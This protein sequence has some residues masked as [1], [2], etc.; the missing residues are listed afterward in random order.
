[1]LINVKIPNVR[2]AGFRIIVLIMTCLLFL[3]VS[4]C[5][6][7]ITRV[8]IT[9][10][11]RV[12]LV[13]REPQNYKSEI[14]EV[15]NIGPYGGGQVCNWTLICETLAAYNVTGIG[16]AFLFNYKAY[17]PSQYVPNMSPR[18]E[19]A[20][21]IEAAHSH[22][23]TVRVEFCILYKSPRNEWKCN[24]SNG[25]VVDWL[26]PTNPE[27]REWIL[28]L[29]EEIVTDY[30]IDDLSLDYIRYDDEDMPY[31]ATAK[32][33]LEEYL[34]E[35]IT[36]WPGDFAPGG[37]RFKE[38]LQWRII[39]I[40]TLVKEIYDLAK[41]IRPNITVSACTRYWGDD[42]GGTLSCVAQDPTAWILD[43]YIDRL[44]PMNYRNTTDLIQRN[45]NAYMTYGT[46]GPKG[47]VE[48]CPYF[49][50]YSQDEGWNLTVTQFAEFITLIRNLGCDG[51]VVSAYM[52]P[53]VNPA[54]SEP[55]PDIRPYLAAVNSEPPWTMYDIAVQ[56]LNASVK[57]SWNTTKP[58]NGSVEYSLNPLFNA[59]LKYTTPYPYPGIYYWDMD[60]YPGTMVKN[61]TATTT[62]EFILTNL[63]KGK[64]YYFRVQSS[65][66]TLNVT[67]KVYVMLASYS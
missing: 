28:N 10:S 58:T 38:F 43:G 12:A 49:V 54:I 30:N 1:M 17:Y 32:A 9:S 56:Y 7:N 44:Y 41:S 53:G 35:T 39:T 3:S 15:V 16:S 8:V 36:N 13:V 59:T 22:G 61:V 67:S 20:L 33:W 5:S 11:G 47:A 50:T 65:I 24:R 26:D 6:Y 46:A 51:Y 29:T 60:Y 55:W 63:E 18:D 48:L 40:N 19:L 66:S 62:H 14:R 45:I 27:A 2:K 31:T 57:I 52:G 21:A 34:G 23:L 25:E 37:S 64:I 42:P 4:V